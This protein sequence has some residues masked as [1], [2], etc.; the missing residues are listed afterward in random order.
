M[1]SGKMPNALL[2]RFLE[3][4]SIDDPRVIVQP[5]IG[6]DTA[7]VSISEEDVIV[8]KSDPITFATNSIGYYAVTVN[9]ND[10]AASGAAPQWFL[11]TILLPKS[12]EVST[13]ER[14]MND[15]RNEC[16]AREITLCGGHTEITDAVIRPV[17]CGM[18][19]GTVPAGS[20]IDK[21][22]METGDRIIMTKGAAV[23]G[24]AVIAGEFS[25]RLRRGG[26]SES[27]IR[28]CLGFLKSIGIQKEAGIAVDSGCVSAMHDVTEGGVS[29][30]LA[31]LSSAGQ[32]VIAVD[33]D[34]IPILSETQQICDLLELDPL[35]LI[36]SG[37]LIICCNAEGFKELIRRLDAAGIPA[38]AIGEVGEEGEGTVPFGNSSRELPIFEVDEITK[39]YS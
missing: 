21:K 19:V 30:A 9:A 3:K 25:E 29:T 36:G 18:M 35:G 16:S 24:T 32:H 34:S 27:S 37:S 17:V 7:A 28:R 13:A 1:K 22:N 31:E 10:V 2:T 6:E 5:S 20:I 4:L 8:L 26:I 12:T 15:I 39:L 14:I 11:S 38:A 33:V 23:E